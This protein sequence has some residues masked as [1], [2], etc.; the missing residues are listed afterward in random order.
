[1]KKIFNSPLNIGAFVLTFFLPFP[2]LMANIALALFILTGIWEAKSHRLSFNKEIIKN[3]ILVAS[4]FF[5]ILLGTILSNNKGK[6]LEFVVRNLP[7]LFLPILFISIKKDKNRFY[8]NIFLGL[9][10]G[11]FLALLICWVNVFL[12][13]V[14]N[15]EPFSYLFRWRHLNHQFT[16]II[17]MHA[18]YMAL[19]V[20]TC[21]AY[22]LRYGKTYIRYKKGIYLLMV[23]FTISLF[24][25]LARTILFFA[26]FSI[27]VFFILNK[28]YK[29]LVL[30]GTIGALLLGGLFFVDDQYDF[31]K[32][33]FYE[34]LPVVGSGNNSLRFQRLEAT[35]KMF[36]KYPLTG[37]GIG[38]SK[39]IRL[40]HYRETNDERALNK[41]FNAHNQFFEYLDELGLLGGLLYISVFGIALRRTLKRE[42]YLLCYLVLLFF[43]ANLTESMLVRTHGITYYS[44]IFS[45][46]FSANYKLNRNEL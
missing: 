43:V 37:V 24:F 21:I 8:H 9:S 6:A 16:E 27:L 19:F 22:L 23:F 1:M 33:K 36:C 29:V 12:E 13:M 34:E 41:E 32:K 38:N 30:L 39:K 18:S 25:L 20:V 17:D 14:I 45:L 35:Q 10:F 26:A 40:E 46:V 7:M 31:L 4:F 2:H 28:N 3:I 44:I 42:E 15:K 11:V 5:L